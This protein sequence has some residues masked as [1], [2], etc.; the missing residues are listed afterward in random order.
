MQ[1][2]F[3]LQLVL[4]IHFVEITHISDMNLNVPLERDKNNWINNSIL[5]RCKGQIFRDTSSNRAGRILWDI[6][7]YTIQALC[8]KSGYM[9]SGINSNAILAFKQPRRVCKMR[10]ICVVIWNNSSDCTNKHQ[11]KLSQ[12]N[13]SE[14]YDLNDRV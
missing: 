1:I 8:T 3:Y 13:C 2:I 6:D 10:M 7:L 11:T 12:C 5:H 9:C 14:M 4:V